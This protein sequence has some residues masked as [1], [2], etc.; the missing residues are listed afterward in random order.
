MISGPSG[1]NRVKIGSKSGPGGGVQLGRC[2][3]GRSGWEGPCS[4][5][6]SPHLSDP[7]EISP[8]L[9]DR[10]SNTPVAVCISVVSQTIAATPRLKSGLLQS[11]DRLTRHQENSF[12]LRPWLARSELMV[13]WKGWFETGPCRATLHNPF[14][15][16][17]PR[18][19][20]TQFTNYGLRVSGLGGISRRN[21]GVHEN[22]CPQNLGRQPPPLGEGSNLVKWACS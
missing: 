20:G 21:R 5:S 10:C 17:C 13:I 16:L 7:T 19:L 12:L 8:L 15:A 18:I 3:R 9:R 2:R 11:K 14:S 1:R 22:L 6:E 4:S